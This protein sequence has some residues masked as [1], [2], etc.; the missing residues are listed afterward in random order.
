[1]TVTLTTTVPCTLRLKEIVVNS[2]ADFDTTRQHVEDGSE[3]LTIRAGQLYDYDNTFHTGDTPDA[4]FGL[5]AVAFIADPAGS[6]SHV[7][8]VDP[9]VTSI[10]YEPSSTRRRSKTPP[11]AVV[12]TD[13][14]YLWCSDNDRFPD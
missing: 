3:P 12:P 6:T 9:T 11:A 5:Y 1:M 7:L 8:Q 4:T 10:V 2:P 14:I 13:V